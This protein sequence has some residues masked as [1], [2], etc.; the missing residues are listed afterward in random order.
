[1]IV[2]LFAAVGL[3]GLLAATPAPTASNCNHPRVQDLFGT[4]F[5]ATVHVCDWNLP[6][7][8]FTTVGFDIDW[9]GIHIGSS[10]VY[11]FQPTDDDPV[12]ETI[13][14]VSHLVV[15]AGGDTWGDIAY[16]NGDV[17]YVAGGY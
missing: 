4:N 11:R 16:D 17:L 10:S 1:M 3:F 2:R 14:G 12:Q 5:Y 7:V 8:D 6:P 15:P 9:A 13:A